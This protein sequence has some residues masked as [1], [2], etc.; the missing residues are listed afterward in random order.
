[1]AAEVHD[2]YGRLRSVVCLLR[3]HGFSVATR[4]QATSDVDGYRIVCPPAL[5]LHYVYAVRRGGG[6]VRRRRGRAAVR[7]RR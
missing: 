5:R 3:R 1:M 4:P 2:I 7:A 6:G